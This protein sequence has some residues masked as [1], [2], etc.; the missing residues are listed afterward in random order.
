MLDGKKELTEKVIDAL[1]GIAFPQ[2]AET[3]EIHIGSEFSTKEHKIEITAGP[4]KHRSVFESEV[5]DVP[6]RKVYATI[7][8]SYSSIRGAHGEI[9]TYVF[10]KQEDE[11]LALEKKIFHRC[12]PGY[13]GEW[14][15][16]GKESDRPV[17]PIPEM[18]DGL[19]RRTMEA[20][21][22]PIKLEIARMADPNSDRFRK[23]VAEFRG[24]KYI[25]SSRGHEKSWLS[26]LYHSL[27]RK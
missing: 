11:T 20:L 25:P 16:N 23:A 9:S 21:D 26:R 18:P 7:F 2:N 17:E 4:N 22:K 10:T 15:Y 13:S 12:F 8:S 3:D 5:F 19:V 6:D 1:R 14:I 24:E 27:F